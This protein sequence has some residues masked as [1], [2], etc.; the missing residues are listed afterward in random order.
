MYTLLSLY[1]WL[2]GRKDEVF[3]ALDMSLDHFNRFAA[4]CASENGFYTAPLIRL[5]PYDMVQAKVHDDLRPH[6]PSMSLAEDWPWWSVPE[7]DLVKPE[8]Q[9]DPRWSKWVSQ[10]KP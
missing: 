9:A 2:D 7:Y 1:L 5:V 3:E 10:L 6:T 4:Y 8:I